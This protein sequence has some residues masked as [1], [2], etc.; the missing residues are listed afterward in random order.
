M[1]SKS[2]HSNLNE[3]LQCNKPK[4]KYEEQIIKTKRVNMLL[5]RIL[6]ENT[7]L[8]HFCWKRSRVLN[9]LG[10]LSDFLSPFDATF[11]I[12]NFFSISLG[13]SLY[14]ESTVH[15]HYIYIFKK[16]S[17]QF[18]CIKIMNKQCSCLDNFDHRTLCFCLVL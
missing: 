10:K 13:D 8:K 12:T 4:S 9:D 18:E 14:R 17:K 7:N 3:N 15:L 5:N 11:D 6:A 2:K 16:N 1:S